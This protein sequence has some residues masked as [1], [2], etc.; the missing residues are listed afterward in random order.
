MYLPI[1]KPVDLPFVNKAESAAGKPAVGSI[2]REV[3]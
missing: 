2:T 1:M 3:G